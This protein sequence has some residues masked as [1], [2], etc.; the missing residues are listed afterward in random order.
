MFDSHVSAF[1]EIH[2]SVCQG[3]VLGP[4]TYVIT[5]ADLRTRHHENRLL[6]YAGDTYLIVAAVMS[7]SYTLQK[8]SSTTSLNGPGQTT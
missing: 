6:K 4:A 7:L 3:S 8:K 5:A 2:A 1:L